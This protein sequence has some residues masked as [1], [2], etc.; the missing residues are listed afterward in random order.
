ML[1]GRLGQVLAGA[2][3]RLILMNAFH[4]VRGRG[5]NIEDVAWLV[6]LCLY[7]TYNAG[8]V[9]VL[10]VPALPDAVLLL[11]PA[12]RPFT[13]KLLGRSRALVRPITLILW[14]HGSAAEVERLVH[15]EHVLANG[16][17]LHNH[18]RKVTL[19]DQRLLKLLVGALGRFSGRSS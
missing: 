8:Y 17:I 12:V 14:R 5:L 7:G 6:R 3:G 11:R 18:R 15:A 13:T 19:V 4:D 10:P 9:L 16:L 1:G 2:L